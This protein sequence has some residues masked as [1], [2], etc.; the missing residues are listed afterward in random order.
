MLRDRGTTRG[1]YYVVDWALNK[2]KNKEALKKGRKTMKVKWITGENKGWNFRVGLLLSAIE[3][4]GKKNYF[5][6]KH[7]CIFLC[8]KIV[9]F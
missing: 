9:M 8:I 7:L 5:S 2:E 3:K 6:N 1:E 4:Y